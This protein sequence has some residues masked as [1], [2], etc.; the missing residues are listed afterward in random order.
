[1]TTDLLSWAQTRPI[2]T[3]NEAER[4]LGQKRAYIRL[5]LHRLAKRGQLI[6]IE[7]GKYTAQ[8]DTMIYA[9]YIETP[10][11][12]SYWTA[13]RYYDLTDQQ[14]TRLHVVTRRNRTDLQGIKFHSTQSMFGYRR[15]PYRGFQIFVADKE[16]LL[17]DCLSKATVPIEELQELAQEIDEAKTIQYCEE[18]GYSSLAK[19]AGYLLERAGKKTGPLL[20]LID[21]NYTPLDLSKPE[22]GERNRRW[23]I[24]V[25]SDAA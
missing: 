10:S 7:R 21:H 5:K 9:S 6:R 25:N 19:R 14:P 20:E 3:L 1:M 8:D 2:F 15:R 13:L 4:A 18:F 24:V 23:K 22:R 17:L 16:R 11:F 12:F